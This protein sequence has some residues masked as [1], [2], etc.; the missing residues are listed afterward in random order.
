MKK[1]GEYMA[2]PKKDKDAV[3]EPSEEFKAFEDFAKKVLSVPKSEIDRRE[4][5]DRERRHVPPKRD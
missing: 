2:Q 3:N 5:L 1:Q 4:E